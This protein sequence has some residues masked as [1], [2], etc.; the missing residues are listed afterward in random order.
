MDLTEMAVLVLNEAGYETRSTVSVR[1]VLHFEGDAILGF[2]CAY[3][4]PTSLLEDWSARQEAFLV[5]HAPALRA[6]RD[7]AWNVYAI[8][9]ARE[10]A[11]RTEERS[12]RRIEEDFHAT[13]KIAVAGVQSRPDVRRGL[14]PILPVSTAGVSATVDPEMLLKQKLDGE[15]QRMLGFLPPRCLKWAG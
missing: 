4:T 13:R 14:A 6:N 8:Y 2:V 7:K 12:L 9:L 1:D 10:T 11:T 15:E 5:R 3:Q